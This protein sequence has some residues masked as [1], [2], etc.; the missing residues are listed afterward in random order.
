MKKVLTIGGATQ[1]I[2]LRHQGADCMTILQKDCTKNYMLFESGE[3]IEVE[4]V[5]YF[6]GGGSTNSAVS[7][8]KLGFDTTC[9]CKIGNDQAGHAVLNDLKKAKV[10]TSCIARSK[11]HSTGTSFIINSLKNERTIFAYRGANGFLEKSE[12]PF[13]QIKKSDQ[14]YITSLSYNSARLLPDIVEFAHKN[15]IPVAIN[16]GISQLARGTKNLLKSLKFIDILILNSFEAEQFMIALVKENRHYGKAFQGQCEQKFCKSE[17]KEP[18]LL[19]S[20]FIY[21]NFFF[22]IR[23]FF[24]ETLKMGPKIVVITDGASGVYAASKKEIFFQPSQK[25]EA[26]NTVGAGDSFGSC[27]VASLLHGH[28]I[29]QALKYSNI[30][31]ASVISSIGAKSGLLTFEQI[32]KKAKFAKVDSIQKFKLDN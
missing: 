6:T 1:D 7:F 13:D 15:K 2:F 19:D 17:K 25:A 14:L 16:P 29:E 31:S 8:K 30:N 28:K 22:S 10:N 4:N 18:R 21:E 12:I 9:F 11:K 20:P 26:I 24:K 27:F 3:K 23:N 32:Q 5:L